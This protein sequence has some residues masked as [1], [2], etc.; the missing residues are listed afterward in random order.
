VDVLGHVDEAVNSHLKAAA[1]LLKRMKKLVLHLKL[2]Q[3]WEAM[4]AA[5]SQKVGLFGAMK[6]LQSV[7]HDEHPV[8]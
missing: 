6:P 7:G 3:E 8:C 4:V 1:R 2:G 5:E